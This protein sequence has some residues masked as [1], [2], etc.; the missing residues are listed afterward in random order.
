MSRSYW[1]AA[2]HCTADDLALPVIRHRTKLQQACLRQP[3]KHG[4]VAAACRACG[5]LLQGL[6]YGIDMGSRIAIVGPNGAGK[7][8]LMN[9]LAGDDRLS[10][11]RG[12]MSQDATGVLTASDAAWLGLRGGLLMSAVNLAVI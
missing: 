2:A 10:M 8:T 7:T 11:P 9:L 1:G 12:L 4:A 5:L 6:N 3:G